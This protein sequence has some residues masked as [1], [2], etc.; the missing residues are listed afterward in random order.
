[1]STISSENLL[2]IDLSLYILKDDLE[3]IKNIVAEISVLPESIYASGI[4]NLYDFFDSPMNKSLKYVLDNLSNYPGIDKVKW[5]LNLNKLLRDYVNFVIPVDDVVNFANNVLDNNTTLTD[6]QI[7]GLTRV[8]NT[9][10]N[11]NI[12]LKMKKLLN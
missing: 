1:M 6:Y 7:A 10:K 8:A 9:I 2:L 3:S 4:F 11:Y 5:D 12:L